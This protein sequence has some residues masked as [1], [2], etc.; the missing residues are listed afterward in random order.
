M[1]RKARAGELI[2]T[3]RSVIPQVEALVGIEPAA[4]AAVE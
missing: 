2:F 1:A 4:E 3:Y